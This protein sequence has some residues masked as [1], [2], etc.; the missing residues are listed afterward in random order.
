MPELA[1]LERTIV[2]VLTE[3]GPKGIQMIDAYLVDALKLDVSLSQVYTSVKRL[4]ARG[5]IELQVNPMNPDF[6]TGMYG[7]PS[8]DLYSLRC[9][10]LIYRCYGFNVTNLL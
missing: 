4:E 9:N 8:T 1:E 6:L 3:Q 5:L 10:G 2:E 7:I